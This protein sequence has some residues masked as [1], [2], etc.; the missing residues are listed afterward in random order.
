MIGER[1]KNL[2]KSM[3]FTQDELAE[4]LSISRSSLS[5]YEIDK[6]DPDSDT[7]NKIADFFQVSLDYLNGRTDEPVPINMTY[8]E[9]YEQYPAVPEY[10]NDM[11][12]DDDDDPVEFQNATNE[13]NTS[14][15]GYRDI[16][17][18]FD[19][20]D[21]DWSAFLAQLPEDQAMH[22]HGVE[23]SDDQKLKIMELARKAKQR[24]QAKINKLLEYP[25]EVIDDA[26]IY[27]A[28]DLEKRKKMNE[29]D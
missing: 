13:F 22:Y 24:K 11:P 28:F 27:A 25:D 29:E 15:S 7:F 3:G 23:Y 6:R 26:L 8:E 17:G 9:L 20:L 5:L 14:H 2:R 16:G 1:L 19:S 21:A 12:R 4:R 18:P 10:Y